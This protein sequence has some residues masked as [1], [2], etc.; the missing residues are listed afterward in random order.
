VPQIT[1]TTDEV[2]PGVLPPIC[3]ICG[4]ATNRTS[5][6]HFTWA[7][8]WTHGMLFIW[9][10]IWPW[11]IMRIVTHRSMSAV[12]PLCR[13]HANHWTKR[14]MV[15]PLGIALTFASM[16]IVMFTG[17]GSPPIW[18]LLIPFALL[19]GSLVLSARLAF[20]GTRVTEITNV[21]I[22]FKEVHAAFVSTVETGRVEYELKKQQWLNRHDRTP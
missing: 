19:I 21:D 20:R 4:E 1:L 16:L 18:A 9:C 2:Q 5:W 22:T 7:P 14:R 13:L 15:L 11:L 6:I 3:M 8:M 12:V 10:T 17:D